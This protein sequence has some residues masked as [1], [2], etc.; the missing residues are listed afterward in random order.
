MPKFCKAYLSK[1][2]RLL[3]KETVPE[4]P[5]EKEIVVDQPTKLIQGEH[6]YQEQTERIPAVVH[7]E[8][9][10]TE[11]STTFYVSYPCRKIA[12]WIHKCRLGVQNKHQK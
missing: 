7:E 2:A 4:K 8:H 10:Q 9:E 12:Y 5:A 6:K 11:L 1:L 3:S